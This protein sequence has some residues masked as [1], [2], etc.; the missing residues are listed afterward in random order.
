M[1]ENT[2]LLAK[3]VTLRPITNA[4]R[5]HVKYK[6]LMIMTPGGVPISQKL[7]SNGNQTLHFLYPNL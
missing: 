2:I 6:T 7:I 1:S 3:Q 4:S 5:W